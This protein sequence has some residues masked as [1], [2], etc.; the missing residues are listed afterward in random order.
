MH[1]FV[2]LAVAALLCGPQLAYAQMQPHRAEYVLRLGN[3]ANAPRIGTA[4]QDISQDCA[5]WHLKRDIASEIALTAS[6]KMALSSK[7]DA[8]ETRSGNN[9]RYRTVQVQN[10]NTRETKGR[11]QKDGGE[12]RTEIVQ[13]GVPPFQFSLPNATLLPVAAIDH[14]IERLRAN[15]T[16][17]PAL[18]FDPEVVGDVFLV[19]VTQLGDDRLRP[20]RPS[21][22]P[23]ALPKGKSWPL[24]MSFTR[25]RQQAQRPMFSVTAQVFE[26]GVLD[27]LTVDTGLVTVT[28]DLQTLE[29][30]PAPN[31]PRS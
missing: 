29:M 31:C 4:V 16:A 10:G 9:L 15:A 6:W 3:A 17:F 1:R 18:T 28:A 19:D 27:R 11:V 20:A 22:K 30:R 24:V 12:L 7:L 13:P 25:G 5:G 26:N 8:E 2:C 23:V 14:L 21:D